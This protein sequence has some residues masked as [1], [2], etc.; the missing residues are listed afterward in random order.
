[1]LMDQCSVHTRLPHPMH[2]LPCGALR[3]LPAA[4][5]GST[6]AGS[7]APTAARS[8]ASV[9]FP[10]AIKIGMVTVGALVLMSKLLEPSGTGVVSARRAAT[11]R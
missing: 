9:T 6:I 4:F 1:V 8:S 7:C 10:K 3:G 2:Q 11:A 5:A